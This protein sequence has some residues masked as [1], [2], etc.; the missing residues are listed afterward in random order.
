MI[1]IGCVVYKKGEEPGTLNAQ[2]C[3]LLA[4]V[5]TGKA[6]GG[7]AEGFAGRYHIHYFDDKGNEV[8]VRELEI[9][10]TGDYYE[11]SWIYH[12]TL[13]AKGIGMEVADS[14]VAGWHDI[15]D[16]LLQA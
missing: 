11:P 14:L 15:D 16:E 7:P 6:T 10:K 5:G 1:N 2:W 4:G 9:D 12:G 3:H 13:R 8:A